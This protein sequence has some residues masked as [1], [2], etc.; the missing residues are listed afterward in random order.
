MPYSGGWETIPC[1]SETLGD[2]SMSLATLKVGVMS[3]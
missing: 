1:V 2:D 3:L